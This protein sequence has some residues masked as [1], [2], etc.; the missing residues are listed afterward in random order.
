MSGEKAGV[1]D[2]DPDDLGAERAV[3]DFAAERDLVVTAWDLV[4]V[5][6]PAIALGC[7]RLE[8]AVPL[9]PDREAGFDADLAGGVF[10]LLLD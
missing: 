10:R 5:R 7:A 6:E 2:R 9:F 8:A 1:A 4:A 3:R